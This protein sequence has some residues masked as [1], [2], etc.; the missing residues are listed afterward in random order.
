MFDAV[1]VDLFHLFHRVA[2]FLHGVEERGIDLLADGDD[3]VAYFVAHVVERVVGRVGAVAEL[4]FLD[5]SDDLVPGAGEKRAQDF[6]FD[7]TDSGEP[8][9]SRAAAYINKDGFREVV[10]MMSHD[11]IVHFLFQAHLLEPV[12]TQFAGGHLDADTFFTGVFLG[13]ETFNA[14][15]NPVGLAEA[16]D[17]LF[18]HVRFLAPEIKVAVQGI[19]FQV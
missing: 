7:G 19:Y 15:G 10:S 2:V 3:R 5:V 1:A 18:V 4:V 16:F 11:D 17:E 13:V 6:I 8:L 9:D 12:V 14:H